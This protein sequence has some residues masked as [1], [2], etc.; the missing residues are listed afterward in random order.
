MKNKNWFWGFFFL[1]AAVFVVASQT[2]SF[3]EI[4]FLSIIA[5]IL[6]VSLFIHSLIKLNFFGV[7]L[8]LAFLYMIYWQPLDLIEIS[9]WVL[10]LTSILISIS[11]SILFNV[12]PKKVEH[13]HCGNKN[14]NQTTENIDDNNPQ[15]KV[16][17]GASS[18]YLHADCLKSGQFTVSFGALEVFFDQAQLSPDGAEI[19]LDCSFGSITL[20]VPKHWKVKESINASLGGVENNMRHSQPTENAPVLTLKGNVRLGGIEIKYI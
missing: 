15:T 19:F 12:H 14:F 11:F 1:L 6:L 7:F 20:Y 3:G 9:N 16:S 2:D 13:W 8:P 18:K 4:G 5:T 17:F 10:I